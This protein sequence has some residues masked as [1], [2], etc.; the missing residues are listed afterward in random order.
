MRDLFEGLKPL[1]PFHFFAEISAI[2]R[3]STHEKAIADYIEGFARERGLWCYRDAANNVFI[4][5]PA[6]PDRVGAPAVLLQAHTDMV[7][8]K[9]EGTVHDFLSDGLKLCREDDL[10]FAEGTTLGAD[11][12]FGVAVMLAVLDDTALSHPP[13]ECL[14]TTE[15]EIGMGGADLF[16][17]SLITAKYMLNLDS[18]EENTVIVGCC[19]GLRSQ[20]MLP[21][22]RTPL[23]GTGLRVSLG[24]LCG[25]HSGEDVHRGRGNALT[26]LGRVLTALREVHSFRLAEIYGGDKT[27]A[28]PRECTALLMGE[29]MGEIKR[30]LPAIFAEEKKRLKAPEDADAVLT[31]TSAPVG[32]LMSEEDTD[33]V[34][35][36]L[37]LQS[38]VLRM[39]EQAPIMP[40]VSRNLANVRTTE[41]AVT[42]GLSSR[43]NDTVARDAAGEEISALAVSLG[44][45]CV[46][47]NPYC[48]WEEPF[49]GKLIE[50]WQRAYRTVTGG[51][52]TPTLIHAG[53]ETGVITSAV[54]GLSAI[55]VGC[56]IHDLHTPRERM[57]LSSFA[58]VYRTVLEFL[59]IV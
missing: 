47:Y 14:F 26:V 17:Y 57:E 12:G 1:A 2:P 9:N 55:A 7:A 30:T 24:G 3:P 25:G 33:R 31:L 40:A 45:T 6:S 43:A 36:F 18:A 27:N 56:N 8:E 28:I 59:R 52:T 37:G 21:V 49:H 22:T 38:G 54:K 20:V 51:E 5:K 50:D 48:G 4:K 46:H 35:S 16:D 13:L 32:V 42:F 58:R 19:G 41:G 11:D 10:L 53:L 34:L 15:E 39:R 29:D 44:G 23:Q